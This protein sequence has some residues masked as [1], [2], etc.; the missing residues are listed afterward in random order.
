MEMAL[1]GLRALENNSDITIVI[2]NEQLIAKHRDKY[3]EDAFVLPDEVL[4]TAIYSI[5]QV[6]E[7]VH[8]SCVSTNL[9]GI[10]FNTSLAM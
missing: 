1:E 2:P 4:Q 6:L 8:E 3:I 10:V 9:I 5:V 7:N